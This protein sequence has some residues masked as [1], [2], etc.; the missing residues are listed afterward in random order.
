MD[1]IFREKK[2]A[3]R[4]Y[5]YEK[6]AHGLPF[7]VVRYRSILPISIRVIL[8]ALGCANGFTGASKSTF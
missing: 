8:L 7:V 3:I 4:H 5:R 1:K 2:T 6:Y